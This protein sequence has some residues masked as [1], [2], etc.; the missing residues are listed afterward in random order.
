MRSAGGEGRSWF[1]APLVFGIGFTIGGLFLITS[2]LPGG[3]SWIV[4]G[5]ISIVV[6]LWVRRDLT[7]PDGEVEFPGVLSREKVAEVRRS[8]RD[9]QAHIATFRYLGVT[10]E[11]CTLVELTLAIDGLSELVGTR[12]YVPLSRTSALVTD[13]KIDVRYSPGQPSHIIVNWGD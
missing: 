7:S 13:R 5:G 3:V 12:L 2:S 8:G 10:F 1:W 4:I 9:A 6:A 11:N